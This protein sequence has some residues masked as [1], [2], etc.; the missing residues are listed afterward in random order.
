MFLILVFILGKIQL[1]LS[2]VLLFPACKTKAQNDTN[3]PSKLMS[4]TFIFTA[5]QR[6]LKESSQCVISELQ[7]LLI[8]RH[9]LCEHCLTNLVFIEAWILF[10][11]SKQEIWEFFFILYIIIFSGY[12]PSSPL[13]AC[14][15][16]PSWEVLK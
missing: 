5:W 2:L 7:T 16:S 14:F 15:D 1:A 10:N 4:T 12:C 11:I 3:Y 8:L 9:S 6:L 13:G